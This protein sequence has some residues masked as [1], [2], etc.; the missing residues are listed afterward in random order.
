MA[1]SIQEHKTHFP[2]AK[3]FVLL[4]FSHRYHYKQMI[5]ITDLGSPQTKLRN[6]E[7]SYYLPL[8]LSLICPLFYLQM[9]GSYHGC[10]YYDFNM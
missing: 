2:E 6:S 5:V 10:F 8:S 1:N 4:S 3:G 7:H 9:F